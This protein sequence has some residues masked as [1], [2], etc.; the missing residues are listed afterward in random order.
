[1]IRNRW[2][3]LVVVAQITAAMV[4]LNHPTGSDWPV[5]LLLFASAYVTLAGFV[6]AERWR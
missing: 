5:A 3:V 2:M 6:R 1:V 4:I